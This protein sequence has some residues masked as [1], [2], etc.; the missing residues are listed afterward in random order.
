MEEGPPVP[1]QPAPAEKRWS[2]RETHTLLD[3][4]RDL[5]LAGMLSRRGYQNREVFERLQAV[6]RRCNV[7][8]SVEQIKDRWQKLKLRYWKLKKILETSESTGLGLLSDFPY[9]DELE[10]LLGVQSSVMPCRREADSSGLGSPVEVNQSPLDAAPSHSGDVYYSVD[11]HNRLAEESDHHLVEEMPQI[12][13]PV[14]P[15][16]ASVAL[17]GPMG[18]IQGPQE[19]MQNRLPL[20][21]LA[22]RPVQQHESQ[23]DLP[24]Q[25]QTEM[26]E[27]LVASMENMVK[28]VEHMATVVEQV[29]VQ[30][31]HLSSIIMKCVAQDASQ[32]EFS[33]VEPV[34]PTPDVPVLV[35]MSVGSLQQMEAQPSSVAPSF[36]DHTEESGQ[37]KSPKLKPC[38]A[39]NRSLV[40]PRRSE[41]DRRPSARFYM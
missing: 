16:Q 13:L 32:E 30:I 40:L 31:T 11:E 14:V 39:H 20:A 7:R 21:E 37:G 3:L 34:N 26:M 28:V 24:R 36:C 35:Q 33:M 6:L 15:E 10:L 25:E 2:E 29:S 27:N 5:R 22:P 41:R 12:P 23:G 9:F 17:A 4:I 19:P 38:R 18:E 8:F 1:A